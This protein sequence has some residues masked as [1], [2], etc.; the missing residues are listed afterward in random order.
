MAVRVPPT[1]SPC[2][3]A[4]MAEVVAM[5]D[6]AFL[7]DNE[8]KDDED[9]DEEIEES[10][11]SDSVIK[12]VKDEGPTAEDEDPAVRDE[13]LVVGDEGPVMGVESLSLGGDEVIPGGQQ[14]AAPVVKTSVESERPEIVSTLR[15]PTLTTWMDPEDCII[16]IDVPAYPLPAPPAQTP[17]SLEWSSGSLSISPVPLPISSL[18]ISLIVPLPIASPATAETEGFLTELGARVEMQGGLIRNHTVRLEELLPAL[19]ERYDRDIGEL[20]TRLGAVG[21]EIF[22]KDIDLGRAALWHAISDTQGENQKLRLHLAK[23]RCAR[24]KLAEKPASSSKKITLVAVEEPVEKPAT[25]ST[26]RRQSTGVQIRETPVMA[27]SKKKAPA[28]TERSKGIELLSEAALLEE[29]QL[30]KDVKRS[31]R[32]INIYQVGGLSKGVDLELEVPDEQK[33]KSIDTGE[34]TSL[35]PGVPDVSKA[36]S[37][38]SEYE[39]WGESKD[40]T[41]DDDKQSDDERT[42]SA[43]LRTNDEEYEHINK[44][45]YDDVNVELKDEETVDEGK[46]DQVKDDAQATVTAAP[47]TQKTKVS[48]FYLIRLC[49]KINNFDNIPSANTKIISMMDIKVQHE[50]LSIQNSPLLTVHVMVIPKTSSALTTT[51][52]PSIPPFIPLLQQ[53][54]LIQTPITIEATTSTTT[55]PDSKTLTT[56]H[57]R[58]SDLEN[59]VKTLKNVDHSL[60]IHVVIKFEVLTVVKVYIGTILDDAL[61]K[62]IQRHTAKLIKECFILADVVEHKALYHALMESILV[63]KDAMNKGVVD[64]SK[65]SKLD[66]ADRDE[67]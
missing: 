43:N 19:F 54:T 4:N 5:S 40:D 53:S 58:L 65:K 41:D 31:K 12:G 37:S 7:E 22:P 25:K 9:E 46:G 39:S 1:M 27:V 47:A 50:D 56:I 11:D 64:K 28:K 34:G 38:K 32:E 24:L 49:H 61:H 67:V 48:L 33:V 2:L 21:D 63:D 3:S 13:G 57:Q 15:H 51:I 52:P 42:M 45:M 30:K 62:V 18:V 29:A 14:R 44:E 10:S 17:P 59:K 16:Y 60:A 55:T 20:F 36:D 26:A 8:E 35:K 23:E 6:L 66:D